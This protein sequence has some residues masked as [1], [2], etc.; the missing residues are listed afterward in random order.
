M[1]FAIQDKAMYLS[2]LPQKDPDGSYGVEG[3]GTLGSSQTADDRKATAETRKS[4]SQQNSGV[5]T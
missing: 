1:E 4:L 3:S 2:Y 5:L